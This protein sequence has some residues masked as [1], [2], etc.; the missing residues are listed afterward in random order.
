[1]INV[2]FYA[3]VLALILWTWY[4]AVKSR[5]SDFQAIENLMKA[6]G[7]R[8][9]S[10]VR[11]YN[12][13]QYWKDLGLS[14]PRNGRIYVALGEDASGLLR[15]VHVNFEG[16]LSNAGG[17]RVLLERQKPTRNNRG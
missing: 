6:R 3:T 12:Y 15:E 10:V 17:P 1:M 16:W 2:I 13:G 8:T 5:P 7:L 14:S 4:D 11:T 9:I